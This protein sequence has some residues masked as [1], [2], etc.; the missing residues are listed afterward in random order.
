MGGGVPRK[1]PAG[2]SR[3]RVLGWV[4]AVAAIS[5]SAPPVIGQARARVLVIGGGAGGAAAARR[6]A[7]GGLDV[8]LVEPNPV[9]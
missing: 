8:T 4:P 5:L 1:A 9:Y 3:R 6:M 7:S 2:P